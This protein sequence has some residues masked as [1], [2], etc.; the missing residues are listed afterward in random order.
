M[1]QEI[2]ATDAAAVTTLGR[3]AWTAY[4]GIYT[5][6]FLLVFGLAPMLWAESKLAGGIALILSVGL[7]AYKVLTLKSY[8]L[9][10]DDMGVWIYSGILPWSKGVNGVK[11]RDLDGAVYFQSMWSWMFKSYSL[12][13][14]H[15]FTKANE[16]LLSHIAHGDKVVLE[17]NN[18]HQELARSNLL[19]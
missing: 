5:L 17:I 4:I 11:W 3:K 16:I 7:V 1:E 8:H 9:Y 18:M 13:I 19:A 15:R 14:G 6:G 10:C 12:Q 2:I